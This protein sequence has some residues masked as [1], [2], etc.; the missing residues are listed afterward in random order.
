MVFQSNTAPP[1][2][3]GSGVPPLTEASDTPSAPSPVSAVAEQVNKNNFTESPSIAGGNIVSATSSISHGI[4]TPRP[5]AF[6]SKLVL[7]VTIATTPSTTQQ[8][9]ANTIGAETKPK[10]LINSLNKLNNLLSKDPSLQQA[11]SYMMDQKNKQLGS[12]PET[13]ME[14][15][16]NLNCEV[17]T[18]TGSASPYLF[19]PNTVLSL[20][21]SSDDSR[22]NND[23]N[24]PEANNVGK[25]TKLLKHDNNNNV[26]DPSN[27]GHLQKL[28]K[29]QK[30][31]SESQCDTQSS[32]T[33]NS[34]VTPPN[35]LI[36]Q[37]YE[38][39]CYALAAFQLLANCV[40]LQD[41]FQ[42]KSGVTCPI[43]HLIKF[44]TDQINHS[45]SSEPYH[46]GITLKSII[47]YL[48]QNYS[49]MNYD[50]YLNTQEDTC[51]FLCYLMRSIQ[52]STN[53]YSLFGFVLTSKSICRKCKNEKVGEQINENFIF[54]IKI[55]ANSSLQKQ[56]E[57]TLVQ[58]KNEVVEDWSCKENCKAATGCF[59][60]RGLEH[61]PPNILFHLLRYTQDEQKNIAKFSYEPIMKLPVINDS[62]TQYI[63]YK[64]SS[65]IVHC[66][67]SIHGGHYF[68]YILK[69]NTWFKCDDSSVTQVKCEEAIQHYQ[70]A[71]L[72]SYKRTQKE[73]EYHKS[74]R[75]VSITSLIE[76][77]I[78]NGDGNL[79]E[80]DS[81]RNYTAQG[82]KQILSRPQE[83]LESEED[84]VNNFATISAPKFNN[85]GMK[86]NSSTAV[87]Q[88]GMLPTFVG[89]TH[90]KHGL[91]PGRV[92]ALFFF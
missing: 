27:Q 79:E 7:S 70:D 13:I 19:L 76:T 25:F 48:N 6:G 58:N 43:Q 65:V 91:L 9:N 35:G 63:D 28:N 31:D 49:G 36:R 77:K 47:R 81:M 39:S 42:P 44:V 61:G 57:R 66:G 11:F 92:F 69:E 38:A 68:C 87:G 20:K 45:S 75:L 30:T 3:T 78:Q 24:L 10:E 18:V 84:T 32:R 37:S 88:K 2:S 23:T 74:L 4:T 83:S 29:R 67:D 8:L 73:S 62:V 21:A 34:A 55:V 26:D 85:N 14:Q 22:K 56:I 53:M 52:P 80:W 90:V 12:I 41:L 72:L 54:Q 71:Y 5:T 50:E 46:P 82:A 15:H 16:H 59:I 51:D 60:Q 33:A 40:N 1:S 64:L 86:Y 89:P 17:S